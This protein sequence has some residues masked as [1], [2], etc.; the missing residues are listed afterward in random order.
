MNKKIIQSL[1][2]IALLSQLQADD[3]IGLPVITVTGSQ[4]TTL[5][6]KDVTDDVTI[7]TQ[8]DIQMT[9][10]TTLNEV[11]SKLGNIPTTQN[12]G[13]G[14]SS[15]I[16]LRGMDA[17]RVLVLIDGVRY[18]DPSTPGATA[19]IDQI[20]LD[21]I[22]QI[23][24][25]KGAQSGV[26]GSDASGG[27]INII[28]KK[29]KQ[30][31][32]GALHLEYG[33]YDTIHTS[34]QSSYATEKYS[35]AASGT[36]FDTDGFSAAA[37]KKSEA[38]YGTRSDALGL[39]N[40]AY[41]NKSLNT[42]LTYN[43]TKKDSI[44]FSLNA[45]NSLVYFDNGGGT[46]S[47]NAIPN[48]YMQNRFYTLDYKHNDTHNT[49][50]V[51]Y[52]RSTFKRES[53][54]SSGNYNYK[55]SVDE[56]KA[57]DKIAYMSESFIRFGG[58]YLNYSQ[59]DV[60]PNVD[61][62]YNAISAFVTNYNKFHLL[63]KNSTILTQ[64]VRYDKYNA[65][66]NALTGKIGLKQFLKD[67]I[68]LS[69]NSGTGYNAPTLGQLYGQWGANPNLKPEKT[70]TNDITFGNDVL[71][72]TGFYNEITDFIG[73]TTEY[74][75]LD[76]TSKIKGIE[77][78]YD[79]FFGDNFEI[80]ALYTYLEAKDAQKQTLARRPKSQADITAIYS[81]SNNIDVNVHIQYIGE[82]YD[83]ADATGAQT[84]RYTT[85]D[86]V[87]NF[88]V[89]KVLSFYAKINNLTDKYYQT[90]D[91]YATAGRSLYTGFTYKF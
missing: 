3:A 20:M 88:K 67:N 26:W 75:Q 63:G 79:D 15:S 72:M 82:R 48:T 52:N 45:I 38:A 18:N 66:D 40:D 69:I 2:A 25:I 81:T 54:F 76:G 9:K 32:H 1:T 39:E 65:F 57:D 56:V 23:E 31:L 91:G 8:E 59:K 80:Q 21:N 7:I 34:L 71:W 78:G 4:G 10:A 19:E 83:G 42:K 24:I 22:K 6:K 53:V 44:G 11:L 60:S 12:G 14:N 55:S 13:V 73:H 43:L 61:K 58:S 49:I 62:S 46:A 89:N 28:T 51:Q 47:D 64:S 90:V 5:E 29:T 33:A 85:A 86:A 84:G 30:G 74:V 70:F 37:P 77:L 16:F 17:R 41:T 36:Y 35:L 50:Q 68:Y 27:V 87:V